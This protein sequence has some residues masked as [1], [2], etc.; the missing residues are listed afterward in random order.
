MSRHLATPI[1]KAVE[2]NTQHNV[3]LKRPAVLFETDNYKIVKW[4]VHYPNH[5]PHD[6]CVSIKYKPNDK[7]I[8]K[9]VIGHD[10]ADKF[11]SEHIASL[12][13]GT[14]Q[15]SIFEDLPPGEYAIVQKLG[16]HI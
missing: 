9:T 10:A 13:N 12:M 2:L 3:V 1:W 14:A 16:D 15:V 7:A 6:I 4:D 5:M 8:S 11:L